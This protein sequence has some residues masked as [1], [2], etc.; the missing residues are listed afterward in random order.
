M[1]RELRKDLPALT[2]V[3]GIQPADVENMTMAEISEYFMQMKRFVPS[4]WFR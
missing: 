3:Y 2:A 4:T 1:R